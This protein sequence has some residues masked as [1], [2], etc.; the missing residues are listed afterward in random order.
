MNEKTFNLKTAGKKLPSMMVKKPRSFRLEERISVAASD[1]YNDSYECAV[2]ARKIRDR[3]VVTVQMMHD[4]IQTMV[5]NNS[6]IFKDME[7]CWNKYHVIKDIVADVRDFIEAEGLKSVIFQHMIKHSLSG[8]SADVENI[9]ETGIPTVK[10]VV[11]ESTRGNIIKNLPTVPFLTQAGPDTLDDVWSSCGDAKNPVPEDGI[12]GPYAVPQHIRSQKGMKDITPMPLSAFQEAAGLK[13][14]MFKGA[15]SS[16][17]EKTAEKTETPLDAF[18]AKVSTGTN[19]AKNFGKASAINHYME[20]T[21]AE[22]EEAEAFYEMVKT[23]C[24]KCRIVIN[25]TSS[26]LVRMLADGGYSPVV[27]DSDSGK[28]NHYVQKRKQAEK[29]I[30]CDELSPAYANVTFLKEGDRKYGECAVELADISDAAILICGDSL[31]LRNPTRADYVD[32]PT[33]ILYDFSHLADCKAAS[34][35]CAMSRNDLSG[36][37]S[38]ALESMR[39]SL[40]KEAGC[41]EALIFKPVM[42]SNIAGVTAFDEP[43]AV[44]IRKILAKMGVIVPV[45]VSDNVPKVSNPHSDSEEKD[46]PKKENAIQLH[47]GISD[48]VALKPMPSHP[49]LVGNIVDVSDGNVTVQ[50]DNNTR[51]IYDMPEALMRLMAAPSAESQD[52]DIRIYSMPGMDNETLSVLSA[53]KVDPVSLY[54]LISHHRPPCNGATGNIEALVKALQDIGIGTREIH[55]FVESDGDEPFETRAWLESELTNGARLVIDV[56]HD[57]LIIRAG[58]ADDYVVP[59]PHPKIEIE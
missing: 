17:Q 25:L 52:S 55:G 7:V 58:D 49:R 1:K 29:I 50:W 4:P 35:I 6:W 30:G 32:D 5:Y 28:F 24:S 10:T 12:K 54:S 42:P 51:T 36:G 23:E 37:P 40:T 46:D 39:N 16:G 33:L 3:Y 41:C 9:Y 22:S 2:T 57:R 14:S 38:N 13:Q 56:S 47:F 44:R 34:I 8:I 48:R 21:G 59:T 15:A 26:S 27:E 45:H 18:L 53:S 11:D 31:R 20:M 43:N 19:D